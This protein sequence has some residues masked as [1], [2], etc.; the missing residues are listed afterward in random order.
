VNK[1]AK[2]LAVVGLSLFTLSS[3]NG[4][5]KSGTDR[6]SNSAAMAT[7]NGKIITE[8]DFNSFLALKRIS[9]D[10]GPRL[11]KAKN[12]YIER[13]ALANAIAGADYLDANL[14]A[15][16]VNEFRKQMLISRYFDK[17]LKDNVTEQGVK[18]YYSNH[19][20]EF[21]IKKVKVAH[22]LLRTR[23]KMSDSEIQVVK[24]KAHEA[25]SALMTGKEF[26]EVVKD[27]SEDKVS[28][29]KGGVL[30]WL[31]DGSIEPEFSKQIFSMSVNDISEPFQTGFGLHIVKLLEG[32]KVINKAFEKV[33]GDI[34]YRMRADAK[35]A[36]MARLQKT[37]KIVLAE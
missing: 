14:T 6:Q 3:L 20:D 31:V 16:E 23:A 7:V 10:A 1:S 2:V 13:E 30:G 32:P 33:Q 22:I 24:S 17:F 4:C 35:K 28:A 11:E 37:I 27:Y 26:A 34:R 12:E 8:S 18:N 9:K 21:Q 29:K 15:A 36:E 19:R 25:Y 5:D